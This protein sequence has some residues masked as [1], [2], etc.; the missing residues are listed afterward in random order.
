MNNTHR[1]LILPKEQWCRSHA[2]LGALKWHEE[3]T[4]TFVVDF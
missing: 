2:Q 4:E 1:R 3:L